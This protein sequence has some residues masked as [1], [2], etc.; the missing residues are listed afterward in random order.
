[1]IIKRAQQD[2]RIVAVVGIGQSWAYALE[3]IQNLEKQDLPVIGTSVT[4]SLMTNGNFF[5]IS[6]DNASE[7]RLAVTF[8]LDKLNAHTVIILADTPDQAVP[9]NQDLYSQ[10][11]AEQFTSDFRHESGTI[12]DTCYYI[13]EE[14]R[15]EEGDPNFVSCN[16]GGQLTIPQLRNY[17][18]QKDPKLIFFAARAPAL[19]SLLTSPG[20]KCNLPILGGSDVPK[21]ANTNAV[22]NAFMTSGFS[23]YYLSFAPAKEGGCKFAGSQSSDTANPPEPYQ[24]TQMCDFLGAY[25]NIYAGQISTST[26][27]IAYNDD[28]WGL[29]FDSSDAMVGYDALQT[30]IQAIKPIENSNITGGV[31]LGELE[32]GTIEFTGASG[33][34]AFSSQNHTSL[35]KP[36]FVTTLNDTKQKQ[37]VTLRLSCGEFGEGRT[38]SS[39]G[40]YCPQRLVTG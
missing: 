15:E 4:G 18:C 11:L 38:E 33:F 40:G 34:I 16:N 31:V 25:R 29:S 8:A 37:T 22:S 12:I 7:A 17:I 19:R 36:I 2:P 27:S 1:M 3:A 35:N 30:V 10:D 5:R 24:T 21:Y 39:Y 9:G 32:S 26:T 20:A 6:P 14:V 13:D 28:R 23:L